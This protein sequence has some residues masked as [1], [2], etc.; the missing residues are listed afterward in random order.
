MRIY[1]PGYKNTICCTS[2]I[3]YIDGARGVLEYRG[4]RIEQLAEQSSFLEVAFLLIYGELP[5]AEQLGAF[6][7][8][9]LM[10]TPPHAHALQLMHSFRHDAH[11][12]SMLIAALAS[13]TALHPDPLPNSPLPDPTGRNTQMYRLLGIMPTLAAMAYR[14]R[15][16][17]EFNQPR[18]GLDYTENF[19]YM[20]DRLTEQEYRPH[21]KLVRAL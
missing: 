15:L 3:S 16:G 7:D 8:N 21:P 17:R 18:E 19:L 1:D 5:S 2:R 6:S 13:Y 4:Y 9:V 10:N 11:P 14:V 12:M 20:L